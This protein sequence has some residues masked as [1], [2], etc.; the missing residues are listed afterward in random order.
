VQITTSGALGAGAFRYS[1][2]GGTSWSGSVGIPSGG[3]YVLP[4]TGVVLTFAGTFTVDDLYTGVSTGPGF[5]NSDLTTALVALR[6]NPLT[7][8]F[9]HVV[10][11]PTSAANAVT[12][13]G[14]VGVQTT[15]A[16]AEFR[17]VFGLV[18]CPQTESDST[19][20]AAA[21]AYFDGRIGIVAGD[22]DLISPLTGL[23]LRRNLAWAY[24]ARLSAIKLST[25]PGQVEPSDNSGPLKN[26]KALYRDERATP[27]LDDAR[28][29]TAGAIMGEGYFITR[30]KMMASTSSDFQQVMARRVMDRAETVAKSGFFQYV[31]KAL[32]MDRI[33]GKIDERDALGIEAN[34]GSKLEAALISEDEASAVQV[35]VS[36]DDNLLSTS[37]L[38]AEVGVVPKG[39]SEIIK[40]GIGFQNP[41]LQAAA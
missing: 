16:E 23:T 22:V 15:A 21:A 11:T 37:I 12:L 18:E 29:V 7:W 2:D 28:F 41:A 5:S 38:N 9:V 36:R 30:G 25:H 4:N 6:A 31:N 39:Y 27:G 1:L 19:I 34:V 26:V 8:G 35:V 10:G 14:V 32:R 24:A 13:A 20:G 17:Y 33:T 3:K 40:V